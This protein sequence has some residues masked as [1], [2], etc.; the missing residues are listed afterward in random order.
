MLWAIR[1]RAKEGKGVW[2][3]TQRLYTDCTG[4]AYLKAFRFG[5][6]ERR[7]ETRISCSIP[8][9]IAFGI[10]KAAPSVGPISCTTRL[11]FLRA[12]VHLWWTERHEVRVSLS[13]RV[14]TR[15]EAHFWALDSRRRNGSLPPI[16][17]ILIFEA[18]SKSRAIPR[19]KT[20]VATLHLSFTSP[21]TSCLTRSAPLLL[22]SARPRQ[23]TG[24]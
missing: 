20:S 11:V 5:D 16:P 19:W 12:K 6:D 22:S 18:A 1:R 3:E 7:S 10:T 23:R 8:L 13:S 24:A 9:V 21:L 4:S 14:G 15:H 2:L 17:R